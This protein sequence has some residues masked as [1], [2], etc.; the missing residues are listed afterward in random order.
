MENVWVLAAVWVGLASLLALWFNS[1]AL[2]EIV[3]GT[4]AQVIGPAFIGLGACRML[5]RWY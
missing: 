5:A 3:V 1:R 4:V 2:T